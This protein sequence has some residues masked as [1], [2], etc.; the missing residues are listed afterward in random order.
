MKD[1]INT[2]ADSPLG[3]KLKNAIYHP[4]RP[5][6]F[7]T[8]EP[9][10]ETYNF[11]LGSLQLARSSKALILTEVGFGIYKPLIYL[12]RSDVK[13][14]LLVKNDESSYCPLKGKAA[15]FDL[16]TDDIWIH[17]IAWSYEE[18]FDFSKKIENSICFDTRFVEIENWGLL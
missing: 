18:C 13:M 6:H 9:S 5:L 15:Y 7:M 16:K 3:L 1:K 4:E 11:R 2:Q 17:K 14:E 8:L 10:G 12:D